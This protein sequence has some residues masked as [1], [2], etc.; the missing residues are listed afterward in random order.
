[1]KIP[2]NLRKN[3][4]QRCLSSKMAPN[5][6]RKTHEDLFWGVHVKKDL[7]DLCGGKFA[8]GAQKNFGKFGEIRAK[9]L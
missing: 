6:C 3:G 4:A 8:K 9:I 2:E 5:V 7:H 1:L